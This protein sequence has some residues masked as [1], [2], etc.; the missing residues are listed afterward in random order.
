MGTSGPDDAEAVGSTY[1]SFDAWKARLPRDP[2]DGGYLVEGQHVGAG[3]EATLKRLFANADQPGALIVNKRDDGGDDRWS[4]AQK[5]NL[6]Y[7]VSPAFGDDHHAVV[8]AMQAAGSDWA[9][10]AAVRFIYHG[11]EDQACTSAND[12]VL[13]EV[14]PVSGTSYNA[15]SF[16]PSSVAK[17]DHE[18]RVDMENIAQSQHKSLHGV[19]AHEL[20]HVLG[21]RHEHARPESNGVCAEGPGWRA[22][23]PYDP[24][25]VMHYNAESP[26]AGSNGGD[27]HLSSLD[28][29][30]AAALYGSPRQGADEG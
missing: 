14:V 17:G 16:F 28:R 5:M 25:S 18:I 21:F 13:F 3:D 9:G 1:E 4:D 8:S 10:A 24:E 26:C 27:Y 6:T 7:C 23:T 22:L 29:A 2:S 30:G 19:L 11:E 15:R 12:R 20:G